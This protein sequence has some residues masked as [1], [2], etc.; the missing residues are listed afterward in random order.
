VEK[1]QLALQ[2]LDI[3]PDQVR[4]V[5]HPYPGSVFSYEIAEALEA[6]GAQGKFWEMHDRLIQEVP[7]DAAEL[8]VL[9]EAVGLDMDAFD[10]ALGSEKYRL[11]VEEAK[12]A[13]EEH[14]VQGLSLFVNESEYSG[15]PGTL[16]DLVYA[17]DDELNRIAAN[18]ES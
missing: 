5:Y 13:A 12:L 11:I 10:D 1:E 17:V 9:A 14:G 3:Y 18:D 2:V 8:E 4:F 6:A 15:Y 7:Q 16:A